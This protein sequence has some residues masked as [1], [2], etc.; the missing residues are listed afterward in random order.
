MLVTGDR[1][2]VALRLSG[3]GRP[4]SSVPAA[5]AENS[6]PASSARLSHLLCAVRR[7]I[8]AQVRKG[9]SGAAFAVSRR[10]ITILFF[11]PEK[12]PV[13]LP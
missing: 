4:A 8:I 2:S 6:K 3:I 11:D 12:N 10:A 5:P 13:G 9:R 7:L 1:V